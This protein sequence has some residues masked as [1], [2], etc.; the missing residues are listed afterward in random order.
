MI[1]AG[2]FLGAPRPHTALASYPGTNSPTLGKSGKISE[3]A[4]VV[5]PSART[6]PNVWDR[7]TRRLG[8]DLNLACDQVGQ[9]W[10]RAAIRHVNHVDAGHHLEQLTSYMAGRSHS[11]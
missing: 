1:S 10:W 2:V 3:R 4:A 8:G 7:C 9:G 6:G 5:T 11:G